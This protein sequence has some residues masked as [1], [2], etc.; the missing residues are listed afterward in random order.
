MAT[1]KRIDHVVIATEDLEDA[2]AKWER[3]LGLKAKRVE[4]VDQQPRKGLAGMICFLQPK[5]SRGVLVE[6]ATPLE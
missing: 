2:A 6:L 1:F 3:N 5:A 4:L